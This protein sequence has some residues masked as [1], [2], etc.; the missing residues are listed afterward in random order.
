MKLILKQDQHELGLRSP[1]DGE[2]EWERR[3]VRAVALNDT[4]QVALIEFTKLN[5]RKLP[6][7]GA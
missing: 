5:S 6:P 3:A 2:I 1:R 4:N 7:R